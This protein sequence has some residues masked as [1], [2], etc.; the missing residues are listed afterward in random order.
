MT[1]GSA[2]LFAGA[3]CY[4]TGYPARPQAL[5]LGLCSRASI[6]RGGDQLL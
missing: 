5:V 4:K 1:D 3:H 2:S 6:V